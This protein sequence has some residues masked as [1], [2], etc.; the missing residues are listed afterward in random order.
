[1]GLLVDRVIA[2]YFATNCWI[3]APNAGE[4][5]L[6]VD[7]GIELPSMVASLRKKLAEHRLSIGAIL[8]TH[9]HL[10]H[11]F[12]LFPVASDFG[13]RQSL[14]HELD[15]DLLSF[16]ERALSTQSMQPEGT[17]SVGDGE[18]LHLG[19]MSV[20]ITHTPGHT[21][22]SIVATVDD[23]VLVSGDTLF[24]G[25]IGRTD[26]PRG[27]ISDMERSLREKIATLPGHLR[28][29]PGHGDE[30]RI[31]RELKENPY[32]LQALAGQLG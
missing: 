6:V 26:L 15:R 25:S 8:I 30:T 2:S 28:V 5:C 4:Q 29:L 18:L 31:E 1:M 20:R 14:V 3:I 11:T 24:A 13:C 21:P 10:D 16:P 23:D 32:V 19:G 17:F 22:G 12:S 9:G 7:P 27:S